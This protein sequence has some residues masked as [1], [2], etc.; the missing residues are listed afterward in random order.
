MNQ[1]NK[2][3]ESIYEA[4]GAEERQPYEVQDEHGMDENPE[5]ECTDVYFERELEEDSWSAPDEWAFDPEMDTRLQTC[6]ECAEGA[7]RRLQKGRNWEIANI[8]ERFLKTASSLLLEDL[9][10]DEICLTCNRIIDCIYE[11]PRL[12]LRLKRLQLSAL[13]RVEAREGTCLESTDVLLDEIARLQANIRLADEG[14]FEQ[15]VQ[16]GSL[17]KDP[18]EWSARYEEVI[19]GVEEELEGQLKDEPHGMGYCFIYWSAKTA[20]LARRGVEWRSPNRMNP[21]VLFD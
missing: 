1:K 7:E 19:D 14:F 9:N 4:S 5:E 13:Q 21:R 17:K 8:A 6:F 12:L 10:V 15:I 20:A 2:S 18:V 16:I 11:H 3:A